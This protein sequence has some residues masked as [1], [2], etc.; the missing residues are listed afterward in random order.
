M[1]LQQLPTTGL[2]DMNH[3]RRHREIT[4]KILNHQ[5]DDSKVQTQAEQ[6][7][8]ITPV[9]YAYPPDDLRR[10]GLIANSLTAAGNNATIMRT[11]FDPTKVG[12]IGT[13]R[14][15]D[16]T[17]SDIYYFGNW[18]DIRPDVHFN[19]CSS[20]WRF[21]KTYAA[22]DDTRGFINIIQRNSIYN[23]SVV[24]DYNGSSGTNAGMAIRVGSRS[25]YPFGSYTNGIFDDDD[26]VDMGQIVLRD[27]FVT[28]NNSGPAA[29]ILILGGLRNLV[30]ENIDIDGQNACVD[31]ILYEFGFS[32]KNGSASDKDWSSSHAHNMHFRNIGIVNLDVTKSL[33][34]GLDITGA[35]SCTVE[36]LYVN[37]AY[38]AFIFRPGE[39]LF[40]HV[41]P[42][43]DPGAKRG[44][45]LR[46]IIG[47]NISNTGAA[48]IGA[49]S[50]S[51]GYLS[52]AG[53]T[54]SQ[55]TDLM[56]FSLDGFSFANCGQGILLS[57]QADIR[58]GQVRSC[59]DGIVIND[60]CVQFDIDN[61]RV[62]DSTNNGIRAVS[63][64]GIWA[65]PR[66]KIGSIRNS[67]IAGTT[68]VGIALDNCR[69]VLIENNRIGYNTAYDASAETNQTVGVNVGT[70]GSGV[71]CRGNFVSTS[72][73]AS[74]YSISGTGPRGCAIYS[75]FGTTSVTG[76]WEGIIL[77]WTATLTP[78]TSGSITAANNTGRYTI[79]DRLMTATVYFDVS[80][81]SSPTGTLT[82]SGLPVASASSITGR[83]S[84]AFHYN[85]LGASS[86]GMSA[87][88]GTNATSFTVNTR[89]G[90]G[91]WSSNAADIIANS[92]IVMHLQYM[93]D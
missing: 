37:T 90:S 93:I 39:A 30:A 23:G 85:T 81:V 76:I 66:L 11:L 25:G 59:F 83:T 48:L 2:D 31:G 5:F 17:G 12:P 35:Y 50:A 27:L 63:V 74:A 64:P 61:V 44:M 45:T 55:Q 47:V 69:S 42:D 56:V 91:S 89:F 3:R 33:G 65:T 40:F 36:N 54:E 29:P 7:V 14:T 57:G 26:G 79:R 82:L 21:T 1:S 16:S 43:D 92:V 4:N 49:E 58:N 20:T 73:G 87:Q 67:Q 46:N 53:L 28:T 22:A 15:P 70:G 19:L 84:V 38:M 72:G 8:G 80:S 32:S 6:L 68:G 62:R 41:R 71:V 88:L 86:T 24:V 60:E 10:F 13:F 9:N 34:G 52:G 77:P 18:F 75:A 51:G 78:G